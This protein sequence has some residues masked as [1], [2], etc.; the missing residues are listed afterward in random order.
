MTNLFESSSAGNDF[1]KFLA[2][3]DISL[4]LIVKV[5]NFGGIQENEMTRLLWKYWKQIVIV[6][7]IAVAWSSFL[8][9]DML[10]QSGFARYFEALYFALS[11]FIIG[12]IDIGLPV[13]SSALVLVLLWIC[14]FLAPLMTLS[15]VYQVIQEKVLSHFSP[16]WKNHSVICGLGRNG[17]LI[18]DLIKEHEPERHRIIVIERDVNNS[19]SVFLQK[20]KTT[21]WLKDDFTQLSVL[22]RAHIGKAKRI[23][24]T[25]NLDITNLNTLVMIQG[26]TKRRKYQQT[27]FHLGNL[28]LHELWQNTF[29][30]DPLYAG[31]KIFNGYQVVTRRLYQR[32]VLGKNYIDPAGNIFIILGYGRFGQML[33][34]HLANDKERQSHDD[35]VVV[36]SRMNIDLR[37]SKF[38]A[39]QEHAV[40]GCFIHNPIEGDIHTAE[41]WDMV[42]GKIRDSRKNAIVFLCRDGDMEN[43]ELAVNMKLGGP[44][45]LRKATIF[46]RLYSN[47]ANEINDIL[48]KSI[49][50]DQSRDIVIFPMQA[51]LKEAFHEE[52]FHG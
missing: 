24:I 23:Y 50:P 4:L 5:A 19:R 25:T 39:A 9:T 13:G 48:E 12:G 34:Y 31:V 14:Y 2:R 47:T 33:F 27:F 51:E 44:A 35:I 28:G 41:V 46:C 3:P 15:I 45:E 43:L 36:A 52:L 11:L 18:Y 1:L 29:L 40:M 26:L 17:R 20:S 21:W 30:K 10:A 38:R 37:Q 7:I 32:W 42:A 22:R 49:T 8:Q 16:R 6:T